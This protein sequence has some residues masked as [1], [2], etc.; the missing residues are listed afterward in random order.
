[1]I[2]ANE[3]AEF[4]EWKR[5]KHQTKLDAAFYDL[6][7][8]INSMSGYNISMPSRAFKTLANA[9]LLLKEEVC[10]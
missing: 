4:K 8:L 6:N 2:D 1:M 5:T 10:K 3:L 7:D 9:L